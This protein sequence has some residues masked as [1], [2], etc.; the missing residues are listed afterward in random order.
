MSYEEA[1]SPECRAFEDGVQ[2]ASAAQTHAPVPNNASSSMRLG[3]SANITFP[4]FGKVYALA[5]FD[6]KLSTEDRVTVVNYME[7]LA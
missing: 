5:F 6:R 7:G 4:L 3:M 1:D 2:V